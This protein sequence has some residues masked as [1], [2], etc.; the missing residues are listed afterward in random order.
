VLASTAGKAAAPWLFCPLEDGLT[1]V[2]SKQQKQ[3][4]ID[5]LMREHNDSLVSFLTVKLRNPQ[6]AAD[7]AQE[8]YVKLLSHDD[9][10]SLENARA[11]L[12][13]TAANL[14]IDRLRQRTRHTA[15]VRTQSALAGQTPAPG[16]GA[17]TPERTAAAKQDLARVM[18]AI[19]E[20]P[21]KCQRVFL[22]HRGRHLT[23]DQ[24]ARDMKLSVSMVEKY[25]IEA[26]RH[27]RKRLSQ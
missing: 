10:Q 1:T 24:I 7:V 27:C 22:L 18:A 15:Y 13:Q 26:L 21:P 20:L 19:R 2:M 9:P 17:P 14:A 25:I 4:F 5:H 23:Y 8:A 12:F 6:D 3:V 16:D 11:Y